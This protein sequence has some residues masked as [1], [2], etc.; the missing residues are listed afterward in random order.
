MKYWDVPAYLDYVQPPLTDAIVDAA[1]EQLG[2]KLPAAYLRLL[3]EQ[4]GGYL[5]AT[6]PKSPSRTLYGIGPSFPSITRDDAWWRPRRATDGAWAPAKRELV[7]PFD[8]DGHWDLCFDYRDRGPRAEPSIA[9]VSIESEVDEPICASFDAFLAGLV[10]GEATKATRLYGAIGAEDVARRLAKH[11]GSD[12]PTADVFGQGHPVWRVALP[13]K[14]AW[15]WTSE[16]RV[17]AGFRREGRGA[18]TRIV[19]TKETVL[20]FPDDPECAVRLS[21]TPESEAAVAE[22]IAKLGL[23]TRRR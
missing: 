21:S 22:A 15:C 9:W 6:W 13:G 4:N 12:E 8:G 16:N 14:H 2:V 7:I 18:A 3:R 5:R 11:F 20:R 17:P 23:K 19:T 10:D 1:E